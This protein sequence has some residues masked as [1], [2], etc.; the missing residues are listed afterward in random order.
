MAG[1]WPGFIGPSYTS[2][3]RLVEC[4]STMNWFVEFVESGAGKNPKA[5][6][7]TPGLKNFIP[8]LSIDGKVRGLFSLNDHC[9]AVV[10]THVIEIYAD[11]TFI[12]YSI[13]SGVFVTDDGEPVQFA[14][15]STTIMIV[16]GGNGYY[17]YG[18]ALA[19]ITAAGFPTGTAAGCGFLDGF[20]IVIK[21]Q[22]QQFQISGLLDVT[23]WDVLD[24]SEAESR[25]DFILS[26]IVRG[27][28]LWLGGSQTFQPFYDSGGLFPFTANQS[29]VLS[30][31]INA[32]NATS[33]FNRA[34]LF[35][36]ASDQTHM[37]A[38]RMDGYEP[39]RIS[40]FAVEA[41][42]EGYAVSNDAIGSTFQIQGH[43]FWQL[44]F[45][46]ANKTWRVDIDT[47][48]WTEVSYFN[49]VTGLEEQ[50]RVDC[51]TTVFDMVVGGDRANGKIYSVGMQ[52]LDDDG[53]IIRRVR[54]SPHLDD[55]LAMRRFSLF[56][57]DGNVGIGLNVAPTANYYN[58]VVLLRWSDDGGENWSNYRTLRC[59]PAGAF[60]TRVLARQLGR[61]R[62]RVFEIVCADPVDYAWAAAYLGVQ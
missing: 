55:S 41:A 52:Y 57:L 47:G 21:A 60:K 31:G 35:L 42:W 58:P 10:G 22:S 12:D 53:D 27:E 2:Y 51:F 19:Q 23:T 39:V 50:H 33:L 43:N 62:D 8:A 49:Q 4:Q 18:G 3:S 59:G 29:G 24:V 44:Q 7:R 6:Y 28:E 61:A 30:I 11:G 15:S 20:F 34:I 13:P 38:Y 46:T 45:P 40:N 54:R 16:G 17:L 56:Q 5:L 26:I 36:G 14:A 25:P 1:A 9:F 32:P 48:D 37:T